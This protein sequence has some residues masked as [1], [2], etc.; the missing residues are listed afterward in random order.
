MGV[1]CSQP[2]LQDRVLLKQLQNELSQVAIPK[3]WAEIMLD[4]IEQRQREDVKGQQSFC[5]NLDSQLADTEAKLDKL[6]NGY[7]D[8][9]IEKSVYAKK[10]ED[11]LKTKVDLQTQ[12]KNF[13][14]KGGAWFELAKD[15]VKAAHQA[16]N[17]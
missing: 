16:E 5:Q 13:G 10:K 11:L 12:I 3:D 14:K 8:G 4:E 6:V 1:N 7:L 9:I 2:Y 17:A 15:W